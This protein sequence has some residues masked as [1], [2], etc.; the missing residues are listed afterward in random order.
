M[1]ILGL[2]RLALAQGLLRPPPPGPDAAESGEPPLTP[3]SPSWYGGLPSQTTPGADD[4][5]Y[6]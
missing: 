4:T 5:H 3:P 6:G 2:R 1:P